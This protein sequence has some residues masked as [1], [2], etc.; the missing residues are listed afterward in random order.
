M[1]PARAWWMGL[2]T[3]VTT[4]CTAIGAQYADKALTQISRGALIYI[5]TGV[6]VTTAGVIKGAT[7]AQAPR[8]HKRRRV[9]GRILPDR[10]REGGK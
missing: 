3:F 2:Y 6:I 9:Y 4:L 10:P 1:P 5:I 7:P 8:H